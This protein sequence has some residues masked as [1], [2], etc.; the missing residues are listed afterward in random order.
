[1]PHAPCGILV[2]FKPSGIPSREALTRLALHFP[3]VK[4]GHAGTLDPAASGVLVVCVGKATRLIPYIQRMPKHYR[5]TL[6][7][8][9]RSSTHDLEAPAEY[10]AVS[11]PVNVGELERCLFKFR[12]EI[13]QVP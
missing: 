4:V 13:L 5:A 6:C 9:R 1:M 3:R 8:G 2:L 12:G 10:V 11:A 7:L